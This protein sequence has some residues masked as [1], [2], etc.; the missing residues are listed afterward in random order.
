MTMLCQ[1]LVDMLT[2]QHV[3][4]LARHFPEITWWPSDLNPQHLRSIEAWRVHD[5][6]QCGAWATGR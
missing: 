6:P 3:V 5:D 2:G 4:D 1:T